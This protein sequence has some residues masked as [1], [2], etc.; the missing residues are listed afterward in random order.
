MAARRRSVA[1][2]VLHAA[3]HVGSGSV[4][5]G[6]VR[7]RAARRRSAPRCPARIGGKY[8]SEAVARRGYDGQRRRRPRASAPR[9]A[10]RPRARRA[11][12]GRCTDSGACTR[13]RRRARPRALGASATCTPP[14]PGSA[15]AGRSTG[16]A[17]AAG[18][19]ARAWPGTCAPAPPGAPAGSTR[20]LVGRAARA[21]RLDLVAQAARRR[22]AP[23]TSQPTAC[24]SP[25]GERAALCGASG[26]GA[27][28]STA[29]RD[30]STS[31]GRSVVLRTVNSAR[32]RSPSR[33]SGGRR[34]RAASGPASS[35]SSSRRCR[36]DRRRRRRRRR[37]GSW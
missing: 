24:A 3:L 29:P 2:A 23:S 4:Q 13:A 25:G 33:T 36:T 19:A 15:S 6:L 5:P 10:A 17:D 22:R 20:T 9:R 32:Q 1:S 26:R 37:C 31:I 12:R 16:C 21:R 28:P 18:R 7:D 34:R 14:R 11:A 35:G 8:L 30:A 27:A